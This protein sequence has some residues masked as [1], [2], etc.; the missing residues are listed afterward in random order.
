MELAE[1]K[2]FTIASVTLD[3]EFSVSKARVQITKLKILTPYSLQYFQSSIVTVIDVDG[4]SSFLREIILIYIYIKK[5][6]I[7]NNSGMHVSKIKYNLRKEKLI[8]VRKTK[9]LVVTT[10]TPKKIRE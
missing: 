9:N 4:Y 10:R 1:I 3:S 5:I 8:S 6:I 7:N 2:F